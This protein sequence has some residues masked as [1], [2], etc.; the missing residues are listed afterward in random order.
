MIE[1]TVEGEYG[2]VRGFAPKEFDH[3]LYMNSFLC[4]LP[5]MAVFI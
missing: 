4:I 1:Y 2:K 3:N 5:D